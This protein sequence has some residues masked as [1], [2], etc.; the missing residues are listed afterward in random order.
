MLSASCIVDV[1]ANDSSGLMAAL[2][3]CRIDS[4]PAAEEDSSQRDACG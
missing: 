4:C 3:A 2:A 1:G